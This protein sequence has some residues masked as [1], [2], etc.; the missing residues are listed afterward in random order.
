[1]GGD[2]MIGELGLS[3]L[4]TAQKNLS[5]DFALAGFAGKRDGFMVNAKLDYLF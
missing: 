3:W 1:M 2:T 5:T 4:P